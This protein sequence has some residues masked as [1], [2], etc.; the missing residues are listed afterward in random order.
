M[1]NANLS[2]RRQFLKAL[3]MF[4]ALAASG[5]LF[6]KS[7]GRL[8]V[9]CQAN[10]YP[11]SPGDFNG[12]LDALRNM[13]SLGYTGFECNVRFVQGQFHRAAQARQEIEQTGVE[14]IGAHTNMSQATSDGFSEVAKG[15][16]ALGAKFMVMSGEGLARDGKFAKPELVHKAAKLTEQSKVCR[17]A[18]LRLAYHNHNP[19]FANHNAEIEALAQETDP[20]LV[21]FLIDGGHAYLGGGDPVAFLRAH[22]KR[23]CG[24]HIKTFKGTAQVPLGQGDFDFAELAATI[25]K[26]HWNGWLITEEGGS[27]LGNT[28]ALGPDREYIRR[29]FGS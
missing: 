28:A 3:S 20:D 18:G 15:V 11:L 21:H 23:V 27:K 4:G 22:S 5:S 13:K 9:G 14:F 17:D 1:T 12:L 6:A 16:H 7:S 26:T 25:R 2:H 29:V 24:F 19:E 10:G 8:H